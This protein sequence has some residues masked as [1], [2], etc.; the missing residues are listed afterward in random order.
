MNRRKAPTTN[1]A[2]EGQA[3]KDAAL[4]LLEARREIFVL[5]GRRALLFTMLAG[6]GTATADDVRALV[7]LPPGIDPR[8]LGSVPGRLGYDKIIGPDEFVRCTRREGH[9]RW[10][11][12]WR[13]IDREKARRWLADHPDRPDPADDN[14]GDD[15]Q[16]VLFPTNPT[17]EP[18]P[19]ADTAG[20]GME[21]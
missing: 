21:N 3:A 11:Q 8:C 15:A 7:S 18:T 16:R 14:Q 17:N 1:S 13:L 10:L 9:A 6:D 2:A 20:A 4:R 5:R 12:R 19:T